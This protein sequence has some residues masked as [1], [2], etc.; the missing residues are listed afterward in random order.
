MS[1]KKVLWPL[2]A[3]ALLLTATAARAH[4]GHGIEGFGAGLAHPFMGWDHLLAMVTVGVWSAAVLPPGRRLAAPALF[5]AM[6]LA[7]ALVALAG[8]VLPLVELVIAMS[9]VLLGAML[10]LGR[11]IPVAPGL[12]LV[13]LVAAVHGHAHGSEMAHGD[14]FA[15]YATGFMLG[16]ALLHAAG[17]AAGFALQ[18]LPAWV[19]QLAAALVGSTGLLLAT[20]L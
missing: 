9:V 18:R 19:G 8:A 6:L 13:A 20:R 1:Y 4:A 12:T 15:L 10:L 5:V 11:R 3:A 14:S 16:S 2:A 7:G 17:L